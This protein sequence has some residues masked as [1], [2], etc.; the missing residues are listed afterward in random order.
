[1][2]SREKQKTRVNIQ[3]HIDPRKLARLDI[4]LYENGVSSKGYSDLMRN[5]VDLVEKSIPE[6]DLTLE[7]AR[8]W[9]SRREFPIEQFL[10]NGK[11]TRP[12]LPI[13]ELSEFPTN[14][15]EEEYFEEHN[16]EINQRLKKL[17]SAQKGI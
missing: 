2:K 10:E 13:I 17:L 8:E 6:M 15:E 5:V 1:M 7:Q 9:F 16:N 4:F 11:P 14:I 12:T 3:L